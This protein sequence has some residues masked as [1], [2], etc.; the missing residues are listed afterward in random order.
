MVYS[1]LATVVQAV[2]L[3]YA[4]PFVV[5]A[6]SGLL[7]GHPSVDDELGLHRCRT[8]DGPPRR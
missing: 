4:V 7:G 2:R 5:A 1:K 8:A 6:D 3:R